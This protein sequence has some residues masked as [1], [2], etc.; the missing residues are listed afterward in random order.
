MRHGQP[1]SDQA[2]SRA[3]AR[4]NKA[5]GCISSGVAGANDRAWL[6]PRRSSFA[7]RQHNLR[8][9]AR[10]TCGSA[11]SFMR[12]RAWPTKERLNHVRKIHTQ[13]AGSR[14]DSAFWTARRIAIAAA[15][16]HRPDAKRRG[17]VFLGKIYFR[18]SAGIA[19]LLDRLRL[20]DSAGLS[21]KTMGGTGLG[22]VTSWV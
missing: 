2:P 16:Q 6:S 17:R 4:R 1:Q 21:K 18:H 7:N 3:V 10:S 11:L 14:A 19:P 8:C 15:V 22:P 9:H 12:Q 5:D 20:V 13:D